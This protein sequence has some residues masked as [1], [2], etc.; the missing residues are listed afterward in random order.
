MRYLTITLLLATATVALASPRL[1]DLDIRVVL[2]HDG[3]A[4]ITETRRMTID[5]EGTEC[6]I[7]LTNMGGSRVRGLW[8]AD[9]TGRRY[10]RLSEWDT[11]L[12]RKQKTGKCGIVETGKGYELCWGLGSEGE[13]TYTTGYVMTGLVRSYPDADA[14]RH[15]FVDEG[16]RPKPEHAVVTIVREDSLPISREDSCGIWAFRY[17]GTINFENGAV[18]AETTEPM[19]DEAGLYVMVV[20]PKGLFAPTLTETDTFEHKKQQALEGSDY[21]DEAGSFWKILMFAGFLLAFFA[22][23]FGLVFTGIKGIVRYRRFRH[24]VL[25]DLPWQRDIP[26]GG[27]LRQ[28]N[29][30]LRALMEEQNGGLIS[31]AILKLVS[32][33]AFA[34]WQTAE[35]DKGRL[36]VNDFADYNAQ[37]ILLRRVYTLFQKAAGDDRM[38]DDG[39]LKAFMEDKANAQLVD[40]LAL[41]LMADK[42]HQDFKDRV[43]EMR[44]VFGLRKFLSEFTLLDERHA[45]EVTLWKDYMVWATL[46]GISRQVM[47]DMRKINPDYFSLD[48]LAAQMANA[49]TLPAIFKAADYGISHYER[50]KSAMRDRYE[51]AHGGGGSSS[52]GGGGGGFSGGGGGGGVR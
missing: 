37:P 22:V 25:N 49:S 8:V 20:F 13:R 39:E 3:S 30:M 26:L 6:F 43:A 9:E 27:D 40:G 32:L 17:T 18:V 42:E 29:L 52:S 21:E 7:G 38:L 48:T 28:A 14:I 19:S 1:H 12:S 44:Q 46:F 33:G 24:S 10:E 34:I 23:F 45:K 47:A 4:V 5:D 2:R 41:H 35:G 16:V 51:R 50:P 31:A 15:V 36:R 11:G